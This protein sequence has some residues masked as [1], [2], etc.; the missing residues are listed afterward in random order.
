MNMPFELGVLL[1]W[2]KETFVISAHPTRTIQA[3]SD[4]NFGDI[5]FH[6][7]RAKVLIVTKR[8]R[9]LFGACRQEGTLE[10]IN[11]G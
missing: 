4:L 6:R 8:V 1:A 2:G 11:F 3:L 7:Q 5:E 9:L 10:L